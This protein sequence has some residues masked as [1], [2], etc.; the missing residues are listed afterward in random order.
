MAIVRKT[1]CLTG[2]LEGQTLHSGRWH[3]INGECKWQ[4]TAQDEP[5]IVAFLKRMWNIEVKD[6]WVLDPEAPEEVSG[7][8]GSTDPAADKAPAKRKSD[9]KAAGGSTGSV[10]KGG[11][12]PG[13]PDPVDVKVPEKAAPKAAPKKKVD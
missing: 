8:D 2:P 6:G 5:L 1:F 4:G 7:R 12:G 3:F 13:T 11:D 9:G 10:S